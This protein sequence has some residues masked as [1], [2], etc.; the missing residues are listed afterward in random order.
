VPI[1][2]IRQAMQAGG[3]ETV[4]VATPVASSGFHVRRLYP[5]EAAGHAEMLAGSADQVAERIIELIRAKG[6]LK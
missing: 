5:P 1:T 6:V 3:I 2:R 4:E